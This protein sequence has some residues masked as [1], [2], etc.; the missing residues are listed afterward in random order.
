MTLRAAR[1]CDFDPRRFAA[2]E[3]ST[4]VVSPAHSPLSR[5]PRHSATWLN[6][7]DGRRIIAAT[8]LPLA[9]SPACI[10][11]PRQ[12][13][14]VTGSRHV[15]AVVASSSSGDE[16]VRATLASYVVPAWFQRGG[17]T[18]SP[19][20]PRRLRRRSLPPATDESTIAYYSL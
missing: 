19:A 9:T 17:L 10:V 2:I 12:S 18:P 7:G 3:A 5:G 20:L 6:R 16:L 4:G 14:F 8:W 11:A 15:V 1:L 13:V